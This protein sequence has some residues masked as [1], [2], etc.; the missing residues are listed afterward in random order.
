M[1]FDVKNCHHILWGKCTFFENGICNGVKE[2][3]LEIF[4][5]KKLATYTMGKTYVFVSIVFLR[6]GNSIAK[7][8]NPKFNKN[9][10]V[11]SF[12]N[13]VLRRP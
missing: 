11:F 6:G 4:S 2:L 7:D 13:M 3:F 10:Q 5:G 9:V 8:I 12:S 1:F